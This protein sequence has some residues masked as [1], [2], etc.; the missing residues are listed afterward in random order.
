[1]A[2]IDYGFYINVYKGAY[3]DAQDFDLYSERACD[4]I[5]GIT[6]GRASMAAKN[7]MEDNSAEKRAAEFAACAQT[8]YLLFLG[9]NGYLGISE[10]E[11]SREEVGNAA[12]SY[13]K[14]KG[15]SYLGIPV[16]GLAL[17]Y[18]KESGLILRGI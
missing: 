16:C 9:E 12:V 13:R 2:Y 14:G 1:M 7:D 10:K 6:D 18:L 8:E 15:I 5:D 3:A 11:I 4:I 17:M